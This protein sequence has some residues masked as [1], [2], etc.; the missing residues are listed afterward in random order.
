[1]NETKLVLENELHITGRAF[2]Y[3]YDM[4]QNITK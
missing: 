2:T 1:M 3:A 4:C